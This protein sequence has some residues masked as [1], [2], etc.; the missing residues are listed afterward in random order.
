MC[1]SVRGFL[2]N[3]PRRNYKG[4]FRHADGRSMT[5]D[6][7]KAQLLQYLSEGKQVIPFGDCD[8]FD[9][10]GEGCRGHEDQPTGEP[11]Q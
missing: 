10:A 7:A 1:M 8:N 11:T 3:A 4:M 5:P 9:Y 6:E 2:M